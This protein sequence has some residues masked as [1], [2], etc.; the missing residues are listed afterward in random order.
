M[1][2]R[3]L[4]KGLDALIPGEFQTEPAGSSQLIPVDQIFP[5]PSQPRTEMDDANLE[6]LANSI[7]EHGV[8]QPLILTHDESS[9]N[10]TLIAGERRLRAAKL[11]GLESVPAVVRQASDLERLELALVE[12]IQR[13]NL[14]PLESAH[15][16]LKL[17][18]EFGLTQ[19]QVAERVS[20][21]RVAVTNTIRLLKLPEE[22]QK[23]LR[24]ERISEGHARTLLGLTSPQAQLAALQTILR[25]EMNVRQ[26]EELVRKLSGI[27][28][29]IAINK[30]SKSAEA[31]SLEARLREQL[32]T[33]VSINETC[34]GG[35]IVIHYYSEEELESI[36]NQILG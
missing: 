35:T 1:A 23:A 18:E 10:Y 8:I 17:Q 27:K 13:E 12:N 19:D 16:Y 22:V 20:K 6:E 29:K 2:R 34:D 21:S 30:P 4:G 7:R 11:A 14:S 25:N 3:G 28:P 31:K 33:K 32:G 36:L 24:E 9:D 26:A 15:A 5:N